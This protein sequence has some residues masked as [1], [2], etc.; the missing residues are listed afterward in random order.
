MAKINSICFSLAVLALTITPAC[1]QTVPDAPLPH[2]SYAKDYAA[3]SA[4]AGSAFMLARRNHPLLSANA[5]NWTGFYTAAWSGR[6][7]SDACKIEDARFGVLDKFGTA[8][9]FGMPSEYFRNA[10]A[11]T[12]GVSLASWI[13]HKTHHDKAA[14]WIPMASG[15]FQTGIAAGNMMGSC[16]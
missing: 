10:I 5:V 4:G 7:I 14:L 16:N 8:K 1:G 6:R 12:A 13:L 15:M 2:F 9:N 3:I 11:A